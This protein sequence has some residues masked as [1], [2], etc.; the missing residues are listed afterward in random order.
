MLWFV[1]QTFL[2]IFEHFLIFVWS[3][4]IQTF[5]VIGV[6]AVC[7][8]ITQIVADCLHAALTTDESHQI[9]GCSHRP[10]RYSESAVPQRLSSF[11][12]NFISLF[13]LLFC[14]FMA[15]DFVLL[16][17]VP[18]INWGKWKSDTSNTKSELKH[19]KMRTGPSPLAIL[20]AISNSLDGFLFLS[21]P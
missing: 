16:G 11:T 10:R 18:H 6:G 7:S 13:L 20:Y 4:W 15:V 2:V 5:L 17:A 3:P 9:I 19:I 14:D 1:L 8:R 12:V 21:C